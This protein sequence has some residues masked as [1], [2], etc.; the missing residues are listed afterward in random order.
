[1]LRFLLLLL[2]VMVL[3]FVSEL[4]IS[5][6]SRPVL[7]NASVKVLNSEGRLLSMVRVEG[8]GMRTESM[9]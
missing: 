4:V 1:M 6:L 8:G 5:T 2:L 7:Y 9:W 3:V